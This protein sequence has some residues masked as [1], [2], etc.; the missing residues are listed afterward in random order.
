MTNEGGKPKT[1]PF[2]TLSEK[3]SDKFEVY[4]KGVTRFDKLSQKY[5]GNPLHGW[6][7]MLAN[8]SYGGLEFII[9][10]GEIIRIPFPFTNTLQEYEDAVN[11]HIRL[12][13]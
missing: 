12:N 8:P 10:Q 3:G 13:G 6:L 7:I 2:I 4:K 9:E 11:T 1:M 5:Y